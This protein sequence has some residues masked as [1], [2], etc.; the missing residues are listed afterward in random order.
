M[1]QRTEPLFG[2]ELGGWLKSRNVLCVGSSGYGQVLKQD[3]AGWA[4][5]GPGKGAFLLQKRTR[6]E[7]VVWLQL[8]LEEVQS[9]GR[10]WCPSRV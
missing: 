4:V 1:S 7:E 5:S 10:A 2:W 6:A 3:E 8:R 9:E